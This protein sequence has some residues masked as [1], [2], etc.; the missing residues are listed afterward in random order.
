MSAPAMPQLGW[1]TGPKRSDRPL[2]ARWSMRVLAFPL[3]GKLAGANLLIVVAALGTTMALHGS[4]PADREMLA[5]VGLSLAISL[6]INLILVALALRPLRALESTAERVRNGDLEARVVASPL[7]DSTVRRVG[8][9][10]NLLLDELVEDRT[11]VRRLASEVILAGDR[12]RA[13]LAR[14]LHD[15]TA[16]TLSAVVMQLATTIPEIHS[17]EA[18]AR[19]ET[20][21]DAVVD[22]LEEVRS[23]SHTV[24]PRVLDDLG[25]AAA[26]RNIARELEWQTAIPISVDVPLVIHDLPTANATV[27]YR[28]A[29]EALANALK[30]GE[31]TGIEVRLQVDERRATLEVTDDGRGF[32]PADPS[33]DRSGLGI[34]SMQER[35]ALVNGVFEL[36]SGP[37]MGTRIRATVPVASTESL[38]GM[39]S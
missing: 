33:R 11:R 31:P 39:A 12:E 20:V 8:A 21:R 3:A 23:L 10:I 30:H 35:V 34:F 22:A 24:H 27:L 2:I 7:A 28:I 29:Q 5:I 9:A 1:P 17:P 13:R 18:A 26:L 6:T 38:R 19:L 15:S 36:V 14:E 16:Q 32:D 37:G 4:A 25:L